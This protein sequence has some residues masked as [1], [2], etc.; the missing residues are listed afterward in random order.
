MTMAAG[1]DLVGNVVHR[2]QRRTALGLGDEG[3]HPLHAQQQ[4]VIGQLAQ[5]AVDGHAA[6]AQL[7]HQLAFRGDPVMRRPGA[8]VDLL[9]DHLLDLGIERSGQ[10]IGLNRQ[11]RRGRGHGRSCNWPR[12]GGNEEF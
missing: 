9:D 4:A 3:A 5:G 10:G 7:L 8:T 1:G 11:F 6:E 12:V 2:E